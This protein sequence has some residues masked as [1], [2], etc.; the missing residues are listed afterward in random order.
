VI[1]RVLIWGL[2]DSLASLEELRPQLPDLPDGD[3]W[4]SNEA[5]ERLGLITFGDDLP[6]LGEIQRLIGKEPDVAEEFDVE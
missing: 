6:D 1:A 5:H 3:Y 2:Y 4:I